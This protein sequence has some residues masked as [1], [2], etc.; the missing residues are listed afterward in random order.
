M[1]VFV[2][3]APALVPSWGSD[4][5]APLGGTHLLDFCPGV[6]V[7]KL[8]HLIKLLVRRRWCWWL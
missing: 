4:G 1:S 2:S 7:V 8:E 6:D 3:E 5:H